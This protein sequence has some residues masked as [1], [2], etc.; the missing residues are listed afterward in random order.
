[1]GPH[2]KFPPALIVPSPRLITR[3][4]VNGLPNILAANFPN[5]IGRNP[6]FYSFTSFLIVSLIAFSNNPVSSSDWTFFI[7]S[8][9]FFIWNY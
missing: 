6:P 9:C 3:L 8:Y 7:I 5:N 2:Q 1:M 4:L